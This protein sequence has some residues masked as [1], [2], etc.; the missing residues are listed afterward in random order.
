[1]AARCA[2]EASRWV[3]LQPA[4]AFAAVPDAV[5][6]TEHPAPPFAIQDREIADRKPKSSGLKAAVATLVD[7]QP[8][9]RL[10]VRKGIDSHVESIARRLGSPPWWELRP[11]PKG[12]GGEGRIGRV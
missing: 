9:A 1:M 4:L 5:L 6:R 10:C 12:A 11:L 3:C 7:Q 8:I 2:H